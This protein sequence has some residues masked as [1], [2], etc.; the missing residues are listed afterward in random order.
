MYELEICVAIELNYITFYKSDVEYNFFTL[1]SD[2]FRPNVST[3]NQLYLE[4][5]KF[6]L[7]IM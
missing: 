6:C 4:V 7:G 5:I 2:I 3:N 1:L